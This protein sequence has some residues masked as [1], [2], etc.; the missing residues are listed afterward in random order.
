LYHWIRLLFLENRI[1]LNKFDRYVYGENGTYANF[2][3]HL[4][5]PSKGVH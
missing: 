2:W 1:D 3:F 5:I 4:N